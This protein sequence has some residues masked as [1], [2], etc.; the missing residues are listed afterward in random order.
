MVIQAGDGG[1][2]GLQVGQ[3]VL[4]STGNR[5][6]AEP[7]PDIFRFHGSNDYSRGGFPA[8]RVVIPGSVLK[9][10]QGNKAVPHTCRRLFKV[11]K[12]VRTKF[13]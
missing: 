4:K 12:D 10:L 11:G 6:G 1:E 2:A 13:E 7:G 8:H 5:C 3:V 9:D